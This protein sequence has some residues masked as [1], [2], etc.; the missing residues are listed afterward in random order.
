MKTAVNMKK[1]FYLS[2]WCCFGVVTVFAQTATLSGRVADANDTPLLGA[3]VQIEGTR[4]GAITLDNGT[5]QIN[6]IPAGDYTLDVSYVGY[7]VWRQ[8]IS[9]SGQALVLNDITLELIEGRL[10]EV[11]VSAGRQQMEVRRLP[12]VQGTYIMAGKKNEVIQVADVNAN[13]SEKTGRQIFAKVPGVFVYDMD[14]SGNQLNIATRGLDPHRSWE[15]NVRQNGIMT[16]TDIYGYPASHYSAPMEAVQRVEIVRGTAAL[17]YGAQFGGMINYIIKEPDTTRRVSFESLSSA[18]SFGLFSTY[19]TIGGKIGKWS[20]HAYYQ[21]RVS[22]GYRDGAASDSEGQYAM[23]QYQPNERMT[24]RAELG[25]ST[26]LYNIPGPLT[27]SMFRENPRQST[28][29]RNYFNP[30]IYLPSFTFD[31]QIGA[32]TRLN[33]VSSAVLGHR[34]SVQF[35][36]FANVPDVVDPLTNAFRSREVHIDRYNSY[37]SELRLVQDYQIGNLPNTLSTGVRYTNNRSIRQQLGQGTTGF[38]FDLTITGEWGRDLTFKTE[39]VAFF[40][41]NMIYLT[42]KLALIPGFRIENG[43][44]RMSG[45]IRYYAPENTPVSIAHM[46]PLF[47]TNVQYK[48]N[49]RNRLYAGWSQA[50]RPVLFADVIPPTSID[51]TDPDLEDSFGYNAEA[52]LSGSL[53]NGALHYDLGIFM[54]QYNNRIGSLILQDAQGESFVFKTNTGDSRTQGVES[55]VE[56]KPLQLLGL[57]P[58]NWNVSFFS[59]TSYFEGWYTRGSAVVRGENLDISGN[60]LETVPRWMSRNGLQF[61]A[62]AMNAT[63]QYSYV[64]ESFSDALN[65]VQPTANGGAGVV[66]AYSLWDFHTSVRFARNYMLRL[67]I[68]NLTDAQYFTKRPSGYPGPG[69]WNS[70]GRSV[71]LTFGVKL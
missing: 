28:R 9:L 60:R 52:G 17:Q 50:Y 13:L 54:I 5:F 38:D 48:I 23:L 63:L 51:V 15:Y 40:T 16:N 66:P 55:Y 29:Q 44:S 69:V 58:D 12:D 45:T 33:F 20:Y 1:F 57:F 37:A 61:W 19:N 8:K 67:S 35:I 27:D 47:G 32:K 7:R 10:R 18:G 3:H 65:T 39:N 11:L 21:K 41:E 68:N 25:R 30:D 56:L 43:I 71:V 2:L 14:G 46:F 70:D 31:W 62:G 4:L 34:S 26:Y 53:W 24:L 36:G 59:A 22:D 6:D 42:S 49:E 64:A